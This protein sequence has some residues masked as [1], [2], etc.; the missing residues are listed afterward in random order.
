[1]T[2]EQVEPSVVFRAQKRVIVPS[3]DLMSRYYACRVAGFTAKRPREGRFRLRSFMTYSM[4]HLND[5][6]SQTSW[7]KKLIGRVPK[8]LLY[9]YIATIKLINNSLGASR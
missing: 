8:P 3:G 9:A 4:L 2:L 1:M 7:G 5:R 6:L